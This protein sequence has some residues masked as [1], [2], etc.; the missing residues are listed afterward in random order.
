MMAMIFPGMDPYL[1]DPQLWPGVHAA[2][3][4][5]VRDQLQPLLEPRYIAAVEERVYLEGP[6]REVIPDVWVRREPVFAGSVAVAEAPSDVP[7]VI[8]VPDL[9]IHESYIEILDRATGQK[10]VTVI[11]VVSPSNKAS[12]AGRDSYVEKQLEVRHS[13]AHLVEIDLLR[14]GPHVVAAPSDWLR[15]L[16]SYDYLVSV[17][18]SGRRGRFEVYRRA[19]RHALP[20]VS[21]PLAGGDP[22]VP[23]KLQ[24]AIRQVYDA[25]RY[26]A[27]INYTR[28]CFPPLSDQDQAWANERI[29][30][31]GLLPQ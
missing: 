21:V 6:G 24:E 29:R 18:R 12:G 28:P 4:I 5:Y 31:A 23:L 20:V 19:L 17:E 10:V 3:I 27:R 1:E 22:D 26:R 15:R 8:V 25:G 16:G 7:E 2:L 13:D 30:A 11:E 14:G 9:E